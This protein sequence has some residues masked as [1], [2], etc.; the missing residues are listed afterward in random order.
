M[1]L[2]TAGYLDWAKDNASRFSEQLRNCLQIRNHLSM[3]RAGGDHNYHQTIVAMTLLR[4]HTGHRGGGETFRS[5]WVQTGSQLRWWAWRTGTD[6]ARPV[7]LYDTEVIQQSGMHLKNMSTT[8]QRNVIYLMF[9]PVMVTLTP[10]HFM[11]FN[12]DWKYTWWQYRLYSSAFWC[13]AGGPDLTSPFLS[14][15]FDVSMSSFTS[16]SYNPLSAKW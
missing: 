6:A 3:C 4:R 1:G 5:H 11:R 14:L 13:L 10:F 2:L 15:S 7:H 16:L 9:V 8:R 12:T